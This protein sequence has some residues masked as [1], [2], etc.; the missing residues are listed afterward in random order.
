MSRSRTTAL[1][2]RSAISDQT[3]SSGSSTAIRRAIIVLGPAKTASCAV[4]S[5]IARAG[6]P[7]ANISNFPLQIGGRG[8]CQLSTSLAIQRQA[9]KLSALSVSL[10][11]VSPL[12]PPPPRSRDPSSGRPARRAGSL[13]T[14]ARL[15]RTPPPR[16]LVQIATS[17]AS[18]GQHPPRNELCLQSQQK[19]V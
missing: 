9:F 10:S 16:I 8:Q 19:T 13:E 5:S 3:I 2:R 4:T 15:K 14:T 7:R 12:L 1:P 17:S 11:R 6:A 18:R